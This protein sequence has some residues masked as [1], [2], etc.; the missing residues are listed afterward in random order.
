[1]NTFGEYVMRVLVRVAAA[2]ASRSS[3]GVASSAGS[4]ITQPYRTWVRNAN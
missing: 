3:S 1:M 4:S 2:A